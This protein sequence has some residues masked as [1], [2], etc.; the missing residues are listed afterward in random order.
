MKK[1]FIKHICD[2]PANIELNF[3]GKI[4]NTTSA[5]IFYNIFGSNYNI[6]YSGGVKSCKKIL[7]VKDKNDNFEFEVQELNKLK[8][9]DLISDNLLIVEDYKEDIK[10][11]KYTNL[12]GL[13]IMWYKFIYRKCEG[14]VIRVCDK[15]GDE[16]YYYKYGNFKIET[17]LNF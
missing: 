1:V 12:A 15:C 6:E 8:F 14:I 17:C 10:V 5:F 2:G 3:T 4:F 7:Q 9:K 11:K 13:W 16:I